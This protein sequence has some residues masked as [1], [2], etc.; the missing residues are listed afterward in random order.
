MPGRTFM[1]CV[2]SRLAPSPTGYLHLGN[3]WSFLL[4]WLYARAAKGKIFLRMDDIDPQRSRAKYVGA[5]LED[6]RWLGLD[7]DAPSN[8]EGEAGIIFQGERIV[9]YERAIGFLRQKNLVYPCFCTRKDLRSLA[10]AP[11]IGDMGAPYP[12]TCRNLDPGIVEDNL[13]RGKAASLRLRC[14]ET[15][16]TFRDFIQGWRSYSLADIGGDFALRRSDGVMA[17]Q[18]ATV[19]D[20]AFY[21]VNFVLRGR[22]LLASTPRQILLFKLLGGQIP[23][24]AHIPLLLDHLG[25]RLAKRHASLAL[26]QLRERGLKPEMIVGFLGKLAGAN[27]SGAPCSAAE[28]LG[29]FDIRKLPENDIILPM[30][31]EEAIE[32]CGKIF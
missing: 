28:L 29:V 18:L 9:D 12:G 2:T 17:Y 32:G 14:P 22:D 21:G 4:N 16:F 24:F 20:D 31:L 19:V 5:A 1:D 11:Q 23:N 26:R 25:Q 13:R 7:W 27:P 30:R 6:L 15:V 3:A 10:S 8:A